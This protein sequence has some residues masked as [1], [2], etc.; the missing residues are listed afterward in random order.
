MVGGAIVLNVF[1]AIW[2]GLG[3]VF[4]PAPLWLLPLPVVLSVTLILAAIRASRFV[5]PR[6]KEDESRVG[7]LIGIWSGA[8]GV[9]FA[10]AFNVLRNIGLTDD[11]VPALAVIVGLHFIPL[12]RGIPVPVYYLTAAGLV[13]AAAFGLLA[14]PQ[15][16]IAAVCFPAGVVLW[17]SSAWIIARAFARRP[18]W[19]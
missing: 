14:P 15:A 16:R 8:E 18:R 9:A 3:L 12:A 7:R 17:A 4:L 11:I 5:P 10:I 19:A 6:T 13:A 1:A 2:C